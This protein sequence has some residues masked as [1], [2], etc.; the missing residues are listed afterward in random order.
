MP[1]ATS[2]NSKDDDENNNNMMM[3]M[4]PYGLSE[5]LDRQCDAASE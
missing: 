2:M 5:Y 1:R 3:G 4:N